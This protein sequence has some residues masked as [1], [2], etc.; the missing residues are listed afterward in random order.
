MGGSHRFGDNPWDAVVLMLLAWLVLVVG[1]LWATP[2]YPFGLQAIDHAIDHT[3]IVAAAKA[4]VVNELH[5]DPD[6]PGPD[7]SQPECNRWEV[8]RRVAIALAAEGAG[9]IAKGGNNCRGFAVDAI[10]Y[11]DGP[12]VDVLG[13]GR[14]GPS[15]PHWMIQ[16][17]RRLASD[18]REPPPLEPALPTLPPVPMP[19]PVSPSEPQPTGS[20]DL[21]AVNAKLDQLLYAVEQLRQEQKDDTEKIQSQINQ[22]VKDAEQTA[23][24]VEESATPLILK[25]LS[26]GMAK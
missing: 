15:T 23:K 19:A 26:L 4:Q 16:P 13:A 22:V 2:A 3:D 7:P 9:L 14:E 8:T 5:L 25:I 21:A 12:V 11:R 17:G 10:M 24:K 20:T 1:L 6:A 18:W